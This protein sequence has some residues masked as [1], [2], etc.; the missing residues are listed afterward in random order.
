MTTPAGRF[1]TT[2]LLARLPRKAWQRLRAGHGTKG[3]RH[4]DRA[5]I[6]AGPDDTP[7]GHDPG[8][9]IL[10]VR[11]HRYTGEL[12]FYRRHSTAPVPLGPHLYGAHTTSGCQTP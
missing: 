10:L 2:S 8:H 9:S 11:R 6:K 4:Y 5:M 3:D 7:P 1:T 12:S